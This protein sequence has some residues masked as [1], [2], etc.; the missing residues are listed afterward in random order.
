MAGWQYESTAEKI[1][2]KVLFE[3]RGSLKKIVIDELVF[4]FKNEVS[5]KQMWETVYVGPVYGVYYEWRV[6]RSDDV[7]VVAASFRIIPGTLTENYA[8]QKAYEICRAL[9]AQERR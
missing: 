9:N 3:I 1:I 4:R 5:S 8:H 6:I 7:S 2:D